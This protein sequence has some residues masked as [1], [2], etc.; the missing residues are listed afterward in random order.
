[1]KKILAIVGFFGVFA[2]GVATSSAAYFNNAPAFRCDTQLTRNLQRGS[3]NSEV[4]VLQ[5][6]L[7]NAGF[8][9]AA[10]NGYFG[11]QTQA[12]VREFQL[13]NGIRPTGIVGEATRNAINER[14]CDVD[15]VDNTYNYDYYGYSGYGYGYSSPTTYVAPNDP[16]V[17][18]VSP[19]P[20]TPTVYATPQNYTSP[21][22]VTI[23][24]PSVIT[25]SSVSVAT[26]VLPASSQIA[27]TGIVYNPS[28]GYTYG[29]T[30]QP[31]S[32]TVGSPVAY[33]TYNEGDTVNVNWTTN[34]LQ[35]S[36]FSIVLESTITGQK[37]TVAVVPGNSY[38]FVLTKELLDSVCAGVCNNNQQGAFK[39]SVTAPVADIASNT[40]ILKATISPITIHRP[41]A[42]LNRVS[43]TTSK[44]PVNSGEVFK[45]YLNIPTGASWN[46]YFMGNYSIKVSAVCP[47]SVSVSIAGTPCGQDFTIP[48][49][50]TSFQQEIPA[51]I[52]NPTWYKQ[53]VVFKLTVINLAG[54]VIGSGET[55]VTA[56]G[57]SFSW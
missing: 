34:N 26:P 13:N 51:S 3:E 4:Y 37:A 52:I 50:P 10:P 46:T 32:I 31:G 42:P 36:V 45:L 7:V 1:M 35:V 12:A 11:Y 57:A 30:P 44:T 27:G 17:Q 24:N 48:L 22:P 2:T 40:T 38:S 39:I 28:S 41:Y 23:A 9:R 25:P 56:N 53:D 20:S 21:A 6:L 29:I 8:L 47:S 43:I 49:A 5:K 55:K 33:A 19:N 14:L 18:V 54:Q 16:Y 15:L